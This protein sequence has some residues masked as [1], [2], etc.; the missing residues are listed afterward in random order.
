MMLKILKDWTLPIAMA[1]GIL[2]H[3]PLG[4]IS[5]IT[6]YLIFVMLLLTFSKLSPRDIR[7]HPLHGWLLLIQLGGC[8]LVYGALRFFSPVAAEGALICVLAPAATSSVVITG[9]LG[10]NVAFLAAYMLVAN[11]GIA[12][13]AP[14][15]FS[16]IGAHSELP[17]I[18]SFFY[19][20]RQVFTL[21][22]L[23]MLCAWAMRKVTPRL[24]GKLVSVHGL[25]FYLWAV[26]LTIVVGRTVVFLIDQ[27]NPDYKEE[28]FIALAALV[29]CVVQF[30]G[31][32][33]LGRRYGDAV[34][35]GQGL[36]QKNT[37]LAIWM[38]QSY[39]NPIASIAPASYVAWQNIIN[40]YQL[41]RKRKG[42]S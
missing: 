27:P 8:V 19:I 32:R 33:A 34:S 14:V 13:F 15:L 2:F 23:P 30:L 31:G 39:L 18:E 40:S 38:A 3:R 20:F 26:A 11:L 28:I 42:G 41:W 37:V 5:F 4:A 7:L 6:P 9:M 22:I 17:F 10:G 29:I 24:H 12:L 25:S 21:L 36:G 16:F 1:V 35:A